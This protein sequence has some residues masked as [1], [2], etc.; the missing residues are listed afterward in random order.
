MAKR[1]LKAQIKPCTC[2]IC[3]DTDKLI[4]KEGLSLTPAKVKELTDRGIAVNLPNANN[5]LQP[6]KGSSWFVEPMFRRDANMCSVWE[7]EQAA[8]AK[9]VG[10]HKRDKQLYGE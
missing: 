5:F 8:K 6:E 9:V 1:I 3:A 4:T 7:Q 10:A 2:T